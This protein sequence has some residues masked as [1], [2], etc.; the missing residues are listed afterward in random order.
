MA[1]ITSDM[2]KQLRDATQAGM[3]DCKKALVETN[4]DFELAKD[5]LRKKGILK[6][7]KVSGR[8]TGE[9]IIYSYI[10]HNN[11]LGVLLELDCVTDFVARTDEFK[12]LAH[13]ISLQLAAMGARFVSRDLVPQEKI[14]KEKEIYAAQAKESGKPAHIIE[15]I[16]ESKLES[17]Y[18]ENCLLEQEY[19]FESGKTINDLIVELI[20]KTGENIKVKK[21]VRWQVGESES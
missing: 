16:V 5:Y 18:K 2:V 14:E 17:F 19:V 9:G 20:S 6:A 4:G 15:K 3:M 21:F 10:H 8:E 1:E 13:K 11:K 12:E 7:D